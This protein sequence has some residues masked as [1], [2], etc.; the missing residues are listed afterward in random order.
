MKGIPLIILAVLLGATGQIVM[1]R[2]MQIYGEVSAVSVW[3][4]LV[5]ILKAGLRQLEHTPKENPPGAAKSHRNRQR[6]RRKVPATPGWRL[7]ETVGNALPERAFSATS[8]L[9]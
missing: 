8:S 3:S 6:V 2:G 5:P 1:K 4:Q 9:R 7:L